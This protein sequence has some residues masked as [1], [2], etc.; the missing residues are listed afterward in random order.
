M[1]SDLKDSL[2]PMRRSTGRR[3]KIPRIPQVVHYEADVFFDI[4]SA[5]NILV[6]KKYK[7]NVECIEWLNE[8]LSRYYDRSQGQPV[9]QHEFAALKLL[10][11]F[12]FVPK[13]LDLRA[14]SI[15]MEFA[16]HPLTAN[17]KISADDYLKQ[18]RF[19]LDT[20]AALN[21]KHN[22][23][24]LG[25]VLL[26]HG[27]IKIIDFTLAEFGVVEI[28]K[29]LPNRHWARPGEDK[30]ILTHLAEIKKSKVNVLSG[31][32]SHLSRIL[33]SRGT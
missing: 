33:Y 12:G 31:V 11:P 9:A 24:L 2:H 15:V 17:S 1:R 8:H 6:T 32:L 3:Q 7:L 19:I 26:D 10:A 22:D 23:L 5:D 4:D 14:D 20:L 13:P 18:C 30:T 25:N 21:F 28:M 29:D 16:G 27:K